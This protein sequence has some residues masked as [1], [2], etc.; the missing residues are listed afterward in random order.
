MLKSVQQLLEIL[1][2][3]SRIHFALLL[4]PMVGVT[5]ME[6]ISIG[7]ILPVIQVLLPGQQESQLTAFFFR[8]FPELV[9]LEKVLL[10]VG[11]FAGFFLIKNL[12]LLVMIYVINKVVALKTALYTSVLFRVYLS[13]SLL[14]HFRLH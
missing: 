8:H 4:I 14:F 13:R 2:L 9:Q 7:L 5:I 1:D 10:M 12:L 3:R 11:I 6:V